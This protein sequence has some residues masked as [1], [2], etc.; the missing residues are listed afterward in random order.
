MIGLP[1][2]G[3]DVI[4]SL[5][6]Q[7]L[8]R[9]FRLQQPSTHAAAVGAQTLVGWHSTNTERSALE[10]A[11]T[12]KAFTGVV[13]DIKRDPRDC[14][15]IEFLNQRIFEKLTD[16]IEHKRPSYESH[17]ANIS[18]LDISE[19]ISFEKLVSQPHQTLT[20]II[21]QMRPFADVIIDVDVVNDVIKQSEIV[22]LQPGKKTQLIDAVGI[23]EKHM[24]PAQAQKV[25]DMCNPA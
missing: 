1:E 12:P 2:C 17:F 15:T 10:L 8:I 20:W 24:S 11:T 25:L 5:Y 22:R 16:F 19:T 4:A 6:G 18:K 3:K 21:S 14:L 7:Y 9:K 13:W 23:W